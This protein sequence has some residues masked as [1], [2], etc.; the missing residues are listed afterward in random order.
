MKSRALILGL[1]IFLLINMF[2]YA[3]LDAKFV[4]AVTMAPAT[5][6]P[7][8]EVTF[9]VNF[10]PVGATVANYKTIGGIDA[11][12]NYQRVFA[13][14]PADAT[15]TLSFKWTA[16]AGNHTVW[17]ELDPD[18]KSGDA[19]YSNNKIEKAFVVQQTAPTGK[20]NLIVNATYSPSPA[21]NGASIT[22]SA[23]VTS[24]GNADSAQCKLG[25]FVSN[26]LQKEFDVPA[27]PIGHNANFT[28]NW[29]A[30]C[31]PPCDAYVS[32]SVDSGNVIDESNEND[33]IWIKK[34]ICDC[35]VVNPQ[36]TNLKVSATYTPTSFKNGDKVQFMIE[37][38]NTSN[39]PS[40]VVHMS[41]SDISG[42]RQTFNII[43]VGAL[44]TGH[45]PFEWTATCNSSCRNKVD[46]FIDNLNE[47]VESNE[48][49]N[50]WARG[51]DCKCLK[52]LPTVDNIFDNKNQNQIVARGK[53]SNLTLEPGSL[54]YSCTTSVMFVKYKVKNTGIQSSGP[55]SVQ[56]QSRDGN[57]VLYSKIQL[58]PTLGPN[59]TFEIML[60]GVNYVNN[61]QIVIT[62][63][64]YNEI[65]ESD[66]TDNLF[67]ETV[68]FNH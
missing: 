29:I 62:I 65:N 27:L 45:Y 61:G 1:F 55:S 67:N 32:F 42:V 26:V 63:D 41:F 39:I 50:H 36:L 35:P 6:N 44:Q 64:C 49:D 22:F 2:A 12:Q 8:D 34:N 38:I 18:H 43:S 68:I 9:T 54:V 40:P 25:F 30:E 20:P 66:E 60:H 17:F 16:T 24:S 59:S 56:I 7:G 4:S 11:T 57:T 21:T 33:N 3:A 51:V 53:G 13:S 28:F 14:I 46:I 31:I 47:A 37:V 48:S 19:N 10:K 23:N 5:A 15:R 58:V 52:T